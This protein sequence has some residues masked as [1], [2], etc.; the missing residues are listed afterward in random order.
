MSELFTKRE[1]LLR[2]SDFV[3]TYENGE[4]RFFRYL[5]LFFR[6]NDLGHP[7]LGITV[8]RKFGKSHD[9][10]KVRRWIREIYRRSRTELALDTLALDLVFN[11][12]G[13]ARE[14]TFDLFRTDLL[15][16]LKSLQPK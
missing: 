9:R 15:R 11:V 5:V 12:K 10:N 7:R 3:A 2:R 6:P 1:R 13:N 16:A 8:T 4:K 14:A